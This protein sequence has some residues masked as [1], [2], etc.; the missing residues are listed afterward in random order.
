[1]SCVLS[2]IPRKSAK[3]LPWQICSNCAHKQIDKM[4]FCIILIYEMMQCAVL[5]LFKECWLFLYIITLINHV[6]FSQLVSS[7]QT[8]DSWWVMSNINNPLVKLLGTLNHCFK[9]NMMMKRVSGPPGFSPVQQL[10]L[11]LAEADTTSALL[12]RKSCFFSNVNRFN[13][14]CLCVN[15][16]W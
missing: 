4:T 16:S 2:W 14:F 7:W 12:R 1:M 11:S 8:G 6:T 15:S 3:A 10:V 5:S 9:P 13:S